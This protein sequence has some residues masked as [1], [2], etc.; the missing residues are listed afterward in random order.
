MLVVFPTW[1]RP[2]PPSLSPQQ[3]KFVVVVQLYPGH[4]DITRVGPSTLQ[5]CDPSW[6]R[7]CA[8]TPLAERRLRT[9]EVVKDLRGQWVWRPPS[10][11]VRAERRRVL[12]QS[13]QSVR[14]VVGAGSGDRDVCRSTGKC[15]GTTGVREGSR[16]NPGALFS[17]S[18]KLGRVLVWEL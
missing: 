6:I 13:W 12:R 10:F 5:H 2:R 18:S 8:G 4:V 7:L 3:T 11:C 16:L 1:T 9:S 17:K 14:D 15:L